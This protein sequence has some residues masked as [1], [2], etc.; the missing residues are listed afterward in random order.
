MKH[1][2]IF[3]RKDNETFSIEIALP[4]AEYALVQE[5]GGNGLSGKT[6]LLLPPPETWTAVAFPEEESNG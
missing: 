4:D 3:F 1:I 6:M 2:L 5:F